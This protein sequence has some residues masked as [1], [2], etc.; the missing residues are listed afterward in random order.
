MGCS[1]LARGRVG[2]YERAAFALARVGYQQP[3]NLLFQ[4]EALTVCS[5]SKALRTRNECTDRS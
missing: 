2:R 1:G 3:M 4:T 5:G